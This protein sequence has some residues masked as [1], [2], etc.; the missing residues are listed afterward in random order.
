MY[1]SVNDV[2]CYIICLSHHLDK[3][4]QTTENVAYT[5]KMYDFMVIGEPDVTG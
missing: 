5:G 3:S 1:N 4:N 2:M